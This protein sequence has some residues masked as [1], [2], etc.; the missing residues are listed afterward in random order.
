MSRRTQ[1]RRTFVKVLGSTVVGLAGC[2]EPAEVLRGNARLTA[3][4]GTPATQTAPGTH[5]LGLGTANRDGLLLVPASYDPATPT[6]LMLSLHGAGGSSQRSI[7][8][9]GPYAE[10][11]GFVLLAPDSREAT[12]DG[13]TGTYGADVRFV[14]DALAIT[15]ARCNISPARLIIEGFSDGASYGL[16]L[17]LAN[18]D[19]FTHV[20]AFS[21][22]FIP[23]FEG[24]PVGRPPVFVAHG[25]NDGVLPI[26][27]T[28]RPIVERLQDQGYD[29]LFV[30]H[31]SGHAIPASVADQ[32][33]A[34]SLAAL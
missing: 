24:D 29:V 11:E 12:W 10:A 7:E 6:P 28:S 26:D 22:G 2:G 9:F 16:G 31:G 30:E 27:A 33:I 4:P 17:G 19:L 13:I 1:T 14:D 20:M 34:W 15:F 21:P 18:G 8:A 3:R 32:A 23:G 25:T 5:P